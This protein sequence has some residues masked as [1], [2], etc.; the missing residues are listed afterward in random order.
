MC[1]YTDLFFL[2]IYIYTNVLVRVRGLRDAFSSLLSEFELSATWL[3]GR[4]KTPAVTAP[5][6]LGRSKTPAVTTTQP[7]GR[8]KTSAITAPQPLGRSRWLLGCAWCSKALPG[9]PFGA[10]WALASAARTPPGCHLGAQK[11]HLDALGSD[12]DAPK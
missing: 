7:L 5:Q 10:T 2:Y 8:S 6:P 3:P 1:G 9:R 4:S 11:W 12:L